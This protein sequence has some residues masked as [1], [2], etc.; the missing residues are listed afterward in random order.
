MDFER[1]G[2]LVTQQD[3]LLSPMILCE[4]SGVGTNNHHGFAEGSQWFLDPDIYNQERVETCSA[5]A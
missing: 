5:W 2:F 4:M 3:G 1:S